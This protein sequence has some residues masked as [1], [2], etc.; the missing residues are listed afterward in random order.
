MKSL[1]KTLRFALALGVVALTAS[2]GESPVS[3]GDAVAPDL[4]SLPP[5]NG[6]PPPS[7]PFARRVWVSDWRKT[8]TVDRIDFC[9][10]APPYVLRINLNNVTDFRAEWAQL[11]VAGQGSASGATLAV[12]PD[13]Y[14]NPKGLVYGPITT[15]SSGRVWSG[16][17][18]ITIN[19][20]SGV[21]SR[22]YLTA[23]RLQ[24]EQNPGDGFWGDLGNSVATEQVDFGTISGACDHH[25]VYYR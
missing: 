25:D 17:M 22:F 16:H 6:G 8:R 2:C 11:T 3:P 1:P 12:L 19:G 18:D 4:L 7:N 13:N 24:D 9:R 10:N 5:Q 20:S 23:V 14:R 15:T 21:D